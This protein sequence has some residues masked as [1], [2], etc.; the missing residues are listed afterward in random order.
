MM[1]AQMKN[2]INI[3]SVWRFSTAEEKSGFDLSTFFQPI[4]T[5]NILNQSIV[6]NGEILFASDYIALNE[7]DIRVDRH[8]ATVSC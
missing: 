8:A 5:Q 4:P 3:F 7:L 2:F 1:N 6:V